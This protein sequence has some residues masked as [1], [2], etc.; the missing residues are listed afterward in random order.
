[1]SDLKSVNLTQFYGLR[2]GRTSLSLD[3]DRNV[4]DRGLLFGDDYQQ[5]FEDIYDKLEELSNA[6]LG[7]KAVYWGDFGLGKTHFL[8]HL[9]Y[10]VQNPDKIGKTPI[11]VRALYV[12]CSAFKRRAPFADFAA[13]LIKALSPDDLGRLVSQYVDM[14]GAHALREVANSDNIADAFGV[15]GN[16]P[17]LARQNA[18]RWLC[19]E[20]L[21]STDLDNIAA[22]GTRLSGILCKGKEFASVIAIIAELVSTVEDKV[23]TFL[24]DEGEKLRNISEPDAYENWIDSLMAITELKKLGLIFTIGAGTRDKLPDLLEEPE[25]QRRIDL[26]GYVELPIL[27]ES[28]IRDFVEDALAGLIDLSI[29]AAAADSGVTAKSENANIWPFSKEGMEAFVLH[30]QEGDNANKPSAILT[31]LQILVLRAYRLKTVPIDESFVE[32][33]LSSH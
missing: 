9:Q 7:Y 31:G 32:G 10:I 14:K 17:G 24:I 27:S 11:A 33:V 30:C 21:T 22:A 25:I 8:R 23:L 1:M 12:K 13:E 4:E 19:G 20:Q 15:I 3:P 6:K 28:N 5:K 2:N 29:S 26:T 18:I 16:F